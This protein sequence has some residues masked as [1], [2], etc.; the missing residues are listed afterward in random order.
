MSNKNLLISVVV[1]ALALGQLVF[2]F[3]G[4][5]D[6]VRPSELKK[7]SIAELSSKG[8]GNVKEMQR[9]LK[10]SFGLLEQSITAKLPEEVTMRREAITAMKGLVRLSEDGI[11]ALQQ[12]AA[13][14]DRDRVEHEYVKIMIATSKVGELFAQVQSVGGV[15]DLEVADVNRKMT[16]EGSLPTD[17]ELPSQFQEPDVMPDPPVSASPYF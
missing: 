12:Y 5:D 10:E 14:R 3:A 13:E 1:I 4:A 7:L 9:M 16:Y 6:G 17:L 8:E 11:V 15:F 2:A